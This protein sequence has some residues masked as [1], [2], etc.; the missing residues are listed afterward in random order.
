M[1]A[2][3]KSILLKWHNTLNLHKQN[4]LC[5]FLNAANVFD[6]NFRLLHNFHHNYR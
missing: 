5:S 6:N 2:L 1:K 3:E 4:I